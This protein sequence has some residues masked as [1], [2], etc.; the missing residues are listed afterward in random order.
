MIDLHQNPSVILRRLIAAN[1]DIAAP[2]DARWAIPFRHRK[3]TLHWHAE[4]TLAK[5]HC[6]ILLDQPD[7]SALQWQSHLRYLRERAQ[8][9]QAPPTLLLLCPTRFRAESVLR[10]VATMGVHTPVFASAQY[11]QGLR[12]AEWLAWCDGAAQIADSFANASAATDRKPAR[13]HLSR[14]SAAMCP[15]SPLDERS[16]SALSVLRVLFQTPMCATDLITALSGLSID[17]VKGALAELSREGLAQR[18]GVSTKD[19]DKHGGNSSIRSTPCPSVSSVDKSLWSLT[20][21]GVQAWVERQLLPPNMLAKYRYFRADHQRRPQHT[22]AAYGFF[23]TLM[24]VCQQRSRALGNLAD[25]RVP[26]ALAEFESECRASDWYGGA[27]RGDLHYWR[28]DGYGALQ[29]GDAITRFWIEIDGTAQA[30]SRHSPIVW[31]RKLIGLCDYLLSERWTFRY[32]TQPSMLVITTDHRNRPLICDALHYA[33]RARGM[34]APQVFMATQA[35]LAQ[36][37]PLAPIWFDLTRS[38]EQPTQA[39]AGL[40]QPL[41]LARRMNMIDMVQHWR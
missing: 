34:D 4:V 35:A 6:Y 17:S 19:T 22:S 16:L 41:D 30:P 29:V 28:P 23:Q 33:A 31:E 27:K 12:K 39:F 3:Q 20:D 11:A 36:R 38:E 32:E 2:S 14:S 1:I 15:P 21:K 5:Q 9:T 37:G 40:D 26:F 7:D 24:Q 8:R 25:G 18:S 10:L 13:R